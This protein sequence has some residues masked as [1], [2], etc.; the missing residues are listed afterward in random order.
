MDE[1]QVLSHVELTMHW[2][3][4]I[5]E[6]ELSGLRVFFERIK[7]TKSNIIYLRLEEPQ[8]TRPELAR[9]VLLLRLWSWM[10]CEQ[11]I[12]SC[13]PMWKKN[14]KGLEGLS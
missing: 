7:T 5:G 10:Y 9:C 3:I 12:E 13:Y 14:S 1:H 2:E 4:D 6:V 8:K 11:N